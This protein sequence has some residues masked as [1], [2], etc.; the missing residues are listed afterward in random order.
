MDNGLA[1][2]IA[3]GIAS[4]IGLWMIFYFIPVGLYFTALLSG[5]RITLI[6]LVFMRWRKVPPTIIVSAMIKASKGGVMVYADEL[7]SHFLAG[8]NVD[9]VVEGLVFAN[10]RAIKT[11]FRE[12][13]QLD[14]AQMDIIEKLKSKQG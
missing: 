11:T 4:L 5:V 1:A 3:I 13:A 10:A 9:K 7:E 2:I 8:G 12:V 6:Q 14:L